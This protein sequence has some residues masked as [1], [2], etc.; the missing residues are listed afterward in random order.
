M[1]RISGFLGMFLLLTPITVLAQT[2]AM[3][4]LTLLLDQ[5]VSCTV[6]LRVEVPGGTDALGG[7]VFVAGDISELGG[8]AAAGVGLIRVDATHWSASV[9]LPCGTAFEYKYTRGSWATV[10][11]GASGEEIANRANRASTDP[12]VIDDVVESWADQW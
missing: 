8:W 10:E 11:K 12:T 9:E 1:K 2:K 5:N 3:P 4:W 6:E 7:S